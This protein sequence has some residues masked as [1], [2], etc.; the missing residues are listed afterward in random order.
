MP[1]QNSLAATLAASELKQLRSRTLWQTVSAWAERIPDKSAL[2]AANDAGDIRRLTYAQLIERAAQLSAGLAS[3]GVRRGDRVALWM[4]NTPE[5]VVSWL[6]IMRIGAVVV[7][8]NTFLKPV[9]VAYVVA[10]SQ[11]RHLLM[12]DAF[13]KLNLPAMLG[14][15]CPEFMAL[16]QPGLLYSETLPE[17]RNVVLFNRSGIR[18]PGAFELAQLE[19]L[20]AGDAGAQAWAA[21]MAR[22]TRGED[23]GMIKYTSGSTGFPK[24]VML[25][26][27]GIVANGTLHSRRI[28]VDGS[29]V[30]FSMM[31]FFHAGGSIWGLMTMMVNGGTLV[32]TEAFDPKQAID[33]L[34]AER[35][36][37]WV[38]VLSKEVCDLALDRKSVV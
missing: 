23:L 35:A 38:S 21:L 7:P 31:P 4:T 16:K 32:F 33:L 13:R 6:A 10:Q 1:T 8:V 22:A 27:G 26:Q 15:I 18:H 14:E 20:G 19:A 37:V 17:L 34:E 29:D 30:Y 9:E 11:A 3:I 5:W 24:G 2:V 25:E 28:G 36:T 12:L